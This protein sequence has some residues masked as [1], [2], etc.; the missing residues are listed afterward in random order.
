MINYKSQSAQVRMK[1]LEDALKN[2]SGK[3]NYIPDDD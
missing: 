2:N 1:S 3:K